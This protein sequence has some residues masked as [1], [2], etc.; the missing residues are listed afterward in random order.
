MNA[1]QTSV[2]WAKGISTKVCQEPMPRFCQHMG[3]CEEFDSDCE[4]VQVEADKRPS[5]SKWDCTCRSN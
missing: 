4:D 2:V 3:L 1:V 5:N